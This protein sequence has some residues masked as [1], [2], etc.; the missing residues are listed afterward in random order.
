LEKTVNRKTIDSESF[1]RILEE[2]VREVSCITRISDKYLHEGVIDDKT[3]DIILSA[4]M[5]IYNQLHNTYIRDSA[6]KEKVEHMIESVTQQIS[7][8]KYNI[9]LEEGKSMGIEEGK[10]IGLE[11]GKTIGLE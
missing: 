2:I 1:N 5:E 9:G 6:V 7:Q 10:T 8:K 4:T 3:K 11:E